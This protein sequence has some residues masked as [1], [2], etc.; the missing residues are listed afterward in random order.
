[1]QYDAAGGKASEVPDQ[2][3]VRFGPHDPGANSPRYL[4]DDDDETTGVEQ[5]KNG[6][7]PSQ[8]LGLVRSW[9]SFSII[10]DSPLFF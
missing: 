7:H 5:S 1:M 10:R 2:V 8:F 4:D 6:Y 9:V 3:H